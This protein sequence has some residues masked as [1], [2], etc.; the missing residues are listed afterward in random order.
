MTTGRSDFISN[1]FANSIIIPEVIL[2]ISDVC[3]R[4]CNYCPRHYS[5]KSPHKYVFMDF[6]VL[7]KICSDLGHSYAGM[8]SFS[9]FGEPTL[10]PYIE[11]MLNICINKCPDATILIITN[12]DYIDSIS[13]ICKNVNVIVEISMHEKFS[14]QK[15]S[16]MRNV[17]KC[18]LLFKDNYTNTCAFN[19]RAGNVPLF[20]ENMHAVCTNC[21]NIPFYKMA[22]DVNG[23]VYQ[24]CSD[25]TRSVIFGNV[26]TDNIYDIWTCSKL[27][28][29]RRNLIN[30]NRKDCV[31][32]S[33][34][35]ANGTFAGNEYMMDWKKTHAI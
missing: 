13:N 34:C 16:H 18:D 4:S 8:F 21:C 20:N 23:D 5:Y 14:V 7:S 9:G 3:N 33:K 29:I 28:Q 19:N 17:I 15:M 24:C 22:V 32:C 12:G 25:W 31:L 30:G 11:K 27:N 35:S 1:C 26:M 6:D 2:N 10:H